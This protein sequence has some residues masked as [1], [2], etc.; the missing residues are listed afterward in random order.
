M[1]TSFSR[2]VARSVAWSVAG[3]AMLRV[4]QLVIGVV[5]ARILAPED[6]GL[7]AVTIVVYTVAVSAGE[8][9]VASAV[10]RTT[11]D[12]DE[13]APTAVTVSLASGALLASAM[14]LVAPVA[15][16]EMGAPDA[17]TPI[18]VMALILLLTG[19]AAVP[20]ALLTRN[21]LQD[22]RF[23]ADLAGFV[24]GNV[25]LVGLA[26]DGWGV[27][28]LAWSRVLG[29]AA[30]VG[31]IIWLSPRRYRPG[32]N[33]PLARWLVGFG[34]PLV[35][36]NLVG[37]AV[38]LVDVAAIGRHLGPVPLG[39]YQLATNVAAWPLAIFLPVL[40]N[41]GLPL[42]SRYRDRHDELAPVLR[43]LTATTGFV[44]FPFAAL[45]CGLAPVLV[46]CLYGSKWSA[47]AP[48][49]AVLGIYAGARVVLALLSD[50]LVALDATRS[51]LLTQ[52]VW[53]VVL[54]PAAWFGVRAD[55]IVGAAIAVVLVSVL[56]T[57]PLSC[58]L[59][60]RAGGLG[61]A[62]TLGGL[63][64]P[65]AASVAA[66]VAAH[67]ASSWT[68]GWSGL[69]LGA[70]AGALIYVVLAGR[71]GQRLLGRFRGLLDHRAD[72]GADHLPDTAPDAV[73][74]TG[75]AR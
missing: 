8:F 43:T 65:L 52:V 59:A 2:Q 51:L 48:V 37:P 30:T 3:A 74:P 55:G 9:G 73:L 50:V 22:R 36:A 33:A 25:L 56:V 70:A 64:V 31:V 69:L 61:L 29:H 46:E 68:G 13:L 72:G 15:A 21:F 1:V 53:V 58:W 32:W 42:V 41:V 63:V 62:A 39:S 18:R 28:A 67:L 17:A 12:L 14:Y 75:A 24:V 47:A 45:L 5:A 34:L 20:G 35:G 49:L 66:G 44:L 11:R 60:G 57:F 6:F 10:I 54:A 19:P 23:A 7:F 26:L 27:L 16:A 40:A 38:A 71:W 4:G